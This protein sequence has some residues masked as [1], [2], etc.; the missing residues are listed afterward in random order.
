MTA[1]R[2]KNIPPPTGRMWA[3]I[4][5]AGQGRRFGGPKQTLP[6]AN[7]TLA[8]T[9]TRTILAARVDGVIVVTRTL[10]VDALDLPNDPQVHIEFNNDAH[11]EM[12]D[13]IRIGLIRIANLREASPLDTDSQDGVLVIPS[14]IPGIS[15]NTCTQCI[16][17]FKQKP[18]RIIIA[19]HGQKSGHPMIFPFEMQSA[20]IQLEGGLNMLP[21]LYADRVSRVSLDEPEILTDIDTMSD[22]KRLTDT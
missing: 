17:A 14:D 16:K 5:A 1:L 20:I 3:I 8:G 7:S 22:Y 19:T 18:N 13:S 4:P 9:I 6:Y 2:H 15:T 10:L 21:K 11:T 12:I